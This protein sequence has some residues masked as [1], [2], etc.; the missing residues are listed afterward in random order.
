V[1]GDSFSKALRVA[2]LE[3]AESEKLLAEFFRLKSDIRRLNERIAEIEKQTSEE[4]IARDTS[5]GS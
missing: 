1:D 3:I 4:A 2:D 5:A